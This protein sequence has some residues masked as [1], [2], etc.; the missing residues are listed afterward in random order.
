M[1]PSALELSAYGSSAQVVAALGAPIIVGV[2]TYTPARRPGV[3]TDATLGHIAGIVGYTAFFLMTAT[4]IWGVLLATRALDRHVRRPTLYGGHMTLAILALAASVVHA[5]VH[6]F[7][8]DAYYDETKIWL[9]WLGGAKWAVAVGIL[10]LDLVIAVA[11]SIWFQHRVSYRR[12]HRFHWL[13]YPGFILIAVHSTVASRETSFGVIW[14]AMAAV[15]FIALA[16]GAMRVLSPAVRREG[17]DPWF[18][19]AEEF[20]NGIHRR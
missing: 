1:D 7:R 14:A 3:T 18:D 11:V 2:A 16:L 6:F 13:A 8:H 15:L 4:V 19:L 10:G 12:W 9:P 20:E 17:Y 5:Q